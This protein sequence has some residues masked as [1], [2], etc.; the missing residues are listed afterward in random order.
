MKKI[1]YLFA[2]IGLVFTTACTP[3]DDINAEIDAQVNPIV[4][5]ATFTLTDDDYADL[6]LSY[7]SFSSLDDAKAALPG[8]LSSKYPQWGKGS[9][10]LVGYKLYV[11]NAFGIS[12]YNLDQDDY[13]FSGSDVLGFEST[14]NPGDFLGDIL[15]ANVTYASEGDYVLAKYFQYSGSIVIVTPEVSLKEN[16][17]YGDV[18][19]DLT[20]MSSDWTAHSGEGNGP[21][22]YAATSLTMTDYPSI[23]V[24]GSL[25][26]GG[27][28]EDVNREFTPITSGKVYYSTLINTSA[29]GDGTYFLHFM[30]DGYGYS[31]RVGAKDDGSGNILFGIGATSSTLDYGT[32]AFA[33]NTTYLLVAS[34][35]I[36]TGTSN[37]YIL[38]SAASSEPASPEATNVGDAGKVV[39][40]IGIR[41]GYG[42][43][44]ATIDGIRVA[45]TWSAIM[46]DE[47]LADEIIG[48][49]TASEMFYT[50]YGG[51]WEAVYSGLYA[52]ES[53]DYDAMGTASGTPGK[54]NNFDSSMDINAYISK[55]LGIKYP[56][57][58]NDDELNVV[59][60]YYSST[61]GAQTR[62]NTYT[63]VDG[64]W[65][66]RESTIS[67]TLQFGHDGS[68]WVPDNTIKYELVKA[69][70]EYL[71]AELAGDSFFDG[72]SLPNLGSYG[73][74]DYNWSDEQLVKALGVLAAHINP[75]AA[76]GQKYT[77]V[78]L[79]YDN[80][81]HSESMNLILTGGVWVLN[82]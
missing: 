62:G 23:D 33:T 16:F 82:I 63:V 18:A 49:K 58:Q 5:E 69:D 11:G 38:E 77:F 46:S 14:V 8:F 17:D 24:G 25:T 79:M 10:A 27:G 35:D 61:S 34:Y 76:E 55:F 39:Q 70:Y 37:L 56:F 78:Y 52:L 7:G 81:L 48:D 9:S 64:A 2:F 21:I 28:S 47:V 6:D 57:A 65:V 31:A 41:Q 15:D 67:T 40:K 29:V 73:D 59:Y 71:A 50:L 45:N 75:G 12:E 68:K 26:L 80:G 43:P 66:G 1:I 44:T 72:V 32:T 13:T 51:A 60:K 54:Y 42:G 20:A 53:D 3:L 22:G 36:E 4:G 74:F 19:G 30:D